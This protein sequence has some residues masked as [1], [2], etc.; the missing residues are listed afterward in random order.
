M[1]RSLLLVILVAGAACADPGQRRPGTVLFASGADLQSMNPLITLHPLA[2]Q[3]QRYV[4]LTTLVRYDSTLRTEPYLA[5]RWEWSA[6]GR[7]LTMHLFDGLRWQDGVPTTARDAAFTLNAARD[8]VTGYPRQREL[9]GMDTVIAVDDS[10]LSIAFRAAPGGLPDVLTDLAV[11]P[12]HWLDSVPRDRM[13]R[14]AWNQA[15]VGNGPF[16]FITHDPNR[17]WVFVADPRFPAALGGPPHVERL[18]VAIVDEPTTKLAALA[19]G[20]LDFAGINPAHASFVEHDPQLAV[21]SYPLIFTYGLILNTRRPP[22]DDPVVRQ[23]ISLAVNRQEIVQG[24]LYGFGTPAYGPVPPGLPGALTPEPVPWDPDSARKLLAGRDVHFDLLTVGSGEAAL[25]QMVQA[26]LAKAGITV[27][28]RQ[29]ELSAFLDRVYAADPAFS[30]AVT[31]IPG[32][33]GLGY[34]S[35]LAAVAGIPDGGGPPAL[36][37]RFRKSTAVVFLYHARGVQG[38]NRRMLDVRMDLRGE[39]ATVSDWRTT[40][41]AAGP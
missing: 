37:E 23:A 2:R 32:D 12:A 4:L 38:M 24:Y 14:A 30:A 41:R 25:E 27:T 33:P 3:V 17:R 19:A 39:L 16:R 31:G 21:L 5:R 35:P 15:P 18:V 1:F 26:Q 40:G 28:I 6:D 13:R 20:E 7:R 9:D 8:P 10:T 36:Q 34:L 22:F 11:A 29:M